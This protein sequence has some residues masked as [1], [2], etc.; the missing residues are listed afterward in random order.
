MSILDVMKTAST[1]FAIRDILSAAAKVLVDKDSTPEEKSEARK[2]Q[3]LGNKK[4]QEKNKGGD[5]TKMMGGGLSNTKKRVGVNDYR[6]G[7]YVLSTV[8]N[9]KMKN[10]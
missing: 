1:V 2:A 10:D 9:R 6:E 3:N 8:D 7:G 5:V 4:V